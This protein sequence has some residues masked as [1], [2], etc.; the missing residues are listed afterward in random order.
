MRMVCAG[1]ALAGLAAAQVQ[2]EAPD[3]KTD[4]ATELAIQPKPA[5]QPKDDNHI[6]GVVPNYTGVEQPP[7]LSAH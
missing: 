6:L 5:A 7:N 1:L 2:Q 3:A 4:S